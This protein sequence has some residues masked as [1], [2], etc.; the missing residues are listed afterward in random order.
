MKLTRME[1]KIWATSIEISDLR[2][3]LVD[4]YLLDKA[5]T[6]GEL[7][8]IWR[9]LAIYVLPKGKYVTWSICHKN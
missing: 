9:N 5:L 2:Q 3:A 4:T 7:T 8:R 1:C 6:P